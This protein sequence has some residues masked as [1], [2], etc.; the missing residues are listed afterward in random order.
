VNPDYSAV[1]SAPGDAAGRARAWLHEVQAAVCDVFDP[2]EF[3]TVVRATRFPSYFNFNL[4]RVERDPGKSVEALVAF[5]DEALA[6]HAHRRIDFELSDVAEPLRSSLARYG[7]ASE[8]LVWMRHE[9]AKPEVPGQ[10]PVEE[11]P[12]DTAA[13]L[14]AGWFQE[15]FPGA[16]LGGHLAEAREVHLLLGA[17]IFAVMDGEDPVGYAQL[18]RLGGTAEITQ[19]YVRADH[20][21]RGIGTALT[22]AAIDA[23]GDVDELWIVGDDEGRPKRLYARLGFRPVWTIV[24]SLRLPQAPEARAKAG[25]PSTFRP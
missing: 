4:V 8:R 21:G 1:M 13:S 10:V 15:D 20:R 2:W 9:T 23:A 22:S 14:R 16:Q 17:R 25:P 3:G 12:Y 5:A 11:V 7:Y 18:E 19:V 24:E 6:E